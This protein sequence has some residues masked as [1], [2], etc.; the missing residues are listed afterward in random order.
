MGISFFSELGITVMPFVFTMLGTL[1]LL[2]SFSYL[3]KEKL[4]LPFAFML[5]GLMLAAI[6]KSL[7]DTQIVT[8]IFQQSILSN[9]DVPAHTLVQLVGLAISSV[10]FCLLLSIFLPKRLRL[11]LLKERQIKVLA[12]TNRQL[13]DD[14]DRYV[15]VIEDLNL[16]IETLVEQ[17][18]TQ[19]QSGSKSITFYRTI[20][21]KSSIFYISLSESLQINDINQFACNKLDYSFGEM[22]N[23]RFLDLISPEERQAA[24]HTLKDIQQSNLEQQFETTLLDRSRNRISIIAE[25]HVIEKNGEKALYLFCRDISKSKKLS[26]EL[27]HQATHDDL[28]QL[29]NRRALE[30]Y[31]EK[32]F[33]EPKEMARVTLIY[34]DMDQFKVVND[35]CGHTAGDQLLKHIVSIMNGVCNENHA[36]VFARIGGDEFAIVLVD[37]NKQ[38]ATV[39]AEQL[40]N[41]VEDFTFVWENKSFRQS[42]S[43]GVAISDI[44]NRSFNE[45]LSAADAACYSAKENGRNQVKICKI[46]DTDLPQDHRSGMLWVSRIEK[47]MRSGDFS[48]NFQPIVQLGQPYASYIHYEV[49][50]HHIDENGK[51]IPPGNFLPYAERFGK[52]S[53]IDLWVMTET[54]DFLSRNAKHTRLLNCCS[55]NL[56]SYS[57]ANERSRGAIISLV[58]QQKFP[59]SKICF[60]ITETSAISNLPEAIEFIATLRSLGCRFALDDF[61]TGF[62][63]FGYLKNL[64]VDYLKIDGTFVRDIVDD[65]VDKVMI[66][67]ISEIAREMGIKTVAEYVEND[68]IMRELIKVNV[69]LGQGFGIAKPMPIESIEDFYHYN[70]NPASAS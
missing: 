33:S 25:P 38:R 31:F 23:F 13:K 69:D 50:M 42:V 35:T 52:S 45:L 48:L 37:Q 65:K 36:A 66:S 67:A 56:T 7:F 39:V 3:K 51:M 44:H 58:R 26:E 2:A 41:A 17:Q 20:I 19:E 61:G 68:G 63:S 40:R 6:P 34:V 46:S 54:F 5:I 24:N 62:S 32:H 64:D 57:I 28:T 14:T 43:V 1:T 55:I 47:A 49:L 18:H 21:D 8:V 11:R 30:T 29:M 60:E 16:E 27:V 15:Q 53:D 22:I 12:K 59:V 4:L 9:V 70:K 10:S